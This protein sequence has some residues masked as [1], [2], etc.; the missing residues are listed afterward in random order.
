MKKISLLVFL[1]T[2]TI[3]TFAQSTSTTV[4]FKKSSRPAL[5]LPLNFNQET[6]EKT[7][8]AKLKETGY[9]PEK[10]GG[11]LNR[12]NKEDGFY[13][14]SGVVLPEL[15]NQK[16]DLYFKVDELK[17]DNDYRSSITLL[18]SE[19]YENF[20]SAENDQATF[21]ASEK[22]LNG[23]VQNTSVFNLNQQL[24]E[25]KQSLV[26]LDKKRT[27]LRN[28]QEDAKRQIVKLEADIKTW[29][30]EEVMQQQEADKLQSAVRELEVKRTSAH[31]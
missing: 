17:N 30:D 21:Q 22:F 31:N 25:K 29:H 7:I 15:A 1:I 8:L 23:F 16:V 11:F 10:S 5:V 26:A 3:M 12:K 2:G 24:E 20:V 13:K 9:Q 4:E 6:A 18:V 27:D 19:G 28:K 14:F